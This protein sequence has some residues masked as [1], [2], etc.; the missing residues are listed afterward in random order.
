MANIFS[1]YGSIFIDNEKANNAIDNT[2]KKGESFASKLGGVFSKVGQGA[3]A[4]GGTITTAALAIGGMATNTAKEV[5]QAMNSFKVSVGG[6]IEGINEFQSVLENVYKNNYGDSFE[7]IANSMSTLFKN[8]DGL[9][10]IELQGLTESALALRDAFGIEVNESVRAAKALMTQFGVSGSEAY[11]LIAQGMQSGLDFS[12]EFIDNINE[13]SVQFSKL[14]LS[15]EDMFNIFQS[16]ANAGAFNLDKIGDAVKEFSIRAIDGSNTTIDGF[17]RL[18]LNADEMA[19]KFAAGGDTAKNAFY[20]VVNAIGAMEDPVEQS[21][22]GVDLFGTM[23]EDLGPEVVTQLGS[24]QNA[25]DKTADSMNEIKAI[26]YDDLGSMFEGLK[27]NVEMLLL[28]LGNAL[29][30]IFVSFIN[31]LMDNMPLIESTIGQLIPIITE[32]FNILMPSI[33]TFIEMALPMLATFAEQVLPLIIDLIS[34]LLPA[35]MQIVE[36]LLPIFVEYIQLLLP[37][38]L[39]I[40]EMILPI[41]IPLIQSLIPLISPLLQLLQPVLDLLIMIVQPLTQLLNIILPPLV[42]ILTNIIQF[43]IPL[44]SANLTYLSNLISSVFTTSINYVIAQIQVLK[45]IF[46][47][48]IDFI[49]N[50]FTGNWSA[51]WENVKNIF[52]N[53]IQGISNSFKL[54]I[55]I[56]IDGMNT[57]IKGLNSLEI[58]DWVPGVGGKSLNIPL[59]KKLRIGMEYVP[60]DDMP[61]LLHKGERVLTAEEAKE[62]KQIQNSNVTNNETNNWNLTINSTEPLSPA[63]T[64]RATRKAIQEINLKHRKKVA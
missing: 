36:A 61:A 64:A 5:D 58:P 22:V 55:N 56:I 29:M 49:R 44:C 13:Y 17:N 38:M 24:I 57:F 15:A 50:V 2:T 59:M 30:P 21:I 51:A 40:I 28:P 39:Q 41:L 3:V 45:N 54:P 9:D 46:L 20:E 25:Y 26:K 10:T 33:Q 62:Y 1:L 31:L 27:R 32:L 42:V 52:G 16:G 63:E 6:N 7:D 53:I 60:Y 43:I 8:L 4:L 18:G 11:N 23:W 12:G 35:I 48:I 34:T 37:P 47:N 14:G 19:Q